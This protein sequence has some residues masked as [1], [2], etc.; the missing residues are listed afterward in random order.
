[1]QEK[2]QWCAALL[3]ERILSAVLHLL[4]VITMSVTM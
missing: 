2:K 4:D 1:M 3:E